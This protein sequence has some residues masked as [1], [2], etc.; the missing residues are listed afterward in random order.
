MSRSSVWLSFLHRSSA[1]LLPDKNI[2]QIHVTKTFCSFLLQ[3]STQCRHMKAMSFMIESTF[4]WTPDCAFLPLAFFTFVPLE[5]L[6]RNRT[7]RQNKDIA[8]R[9]GY[10]INLKKIVTAE[11][12]RNQ[13]IKLSSQNVLNIVYLATTNLNWTS[14]STHEVGR[15]IRFLKLFHKEQG[16]IKQTKDKQ[17]VS[18]NV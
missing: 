15:S 2:Q 4:S 9:L 6:I 5:G 10:N 11:S 7:L 17:R 1:C 13:K 18:I 3:F 8:V 14:M 12:R 16:T